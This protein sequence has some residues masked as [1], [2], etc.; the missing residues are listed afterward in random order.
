MRDTLRSYLA[1][2]VGVFCIGWSA[3]FVKLAH[4]DGL[5]SAFYRLFFATAVLGPWWVARRPARPLSSRALVL[6]A[7]GAIFFAFD[8]A[9]W[10]VSI[11]RTSATT[12]TLLANNAP[13]W[14]GLGTVLVWRERLSG[15]F[16]IG[17]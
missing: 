17:V 5:S 15:A 11:L 16:W 7:V 14:V 8:L 4:V 1:L 12:A 3:I 13:I 10:N 6:T 2:A 9:L